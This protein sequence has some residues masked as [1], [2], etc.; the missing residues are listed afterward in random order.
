MKFLQAIPKEEKTDDD[1]PSTSCK[2]SFF[3][4]PKKK[5]KTQESALD[6]VER[7]IKTENL[8]PAELLNLFP[9]I[10]KLFIMFNTTLPS[11]ASVERLF[12]HAGLIFGKKRQLLSD[13]NF[14]LQLMLKLNKDFYNQ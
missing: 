4:P 2:S 1:Q 13:K 11:S 3:F 10:K 7:F 5:M 6:M 9:Y 12:S 14:E 8:E